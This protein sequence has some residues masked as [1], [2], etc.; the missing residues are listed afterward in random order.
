MDKKQLTEADK[1]AGF[2]S[3]LPGFELHVSNDETKKAV[4]AI[5]K[6]MIPVFW[7]IEDYIKLYF[8]ERYNHE[9]KILSQEWRLIFA[10]HQFE[11]TLEQPESEA[12]EAQTKTPDNE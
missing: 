3:D 6:S 4:K 10:L 8:K 12:N 5:A 2:I 7:N 9:V 11:K 1:I